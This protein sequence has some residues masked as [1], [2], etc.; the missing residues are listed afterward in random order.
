M[1]YVFV[2]LIAICSIPAMA[3]RPNTTKLTYRDAAGLVDSAGAIVLSTGANTFDRYVAN[4]GFCGND[5]VAVN[6]YAPT[7][8][9]DSCLIGLACVDK[10]DHVS[11]KIV[12]KPITCKEGK[13]GI[14]YESNGYNDNQI[15]VPVVCKAGKW[16]RQDGKKAAAPKKIVCKEGRVQYFLENNGINDN[17]VSVRYVCHSGKYV[18]D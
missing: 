4:Q 12:Q 9:K 15:A 11:S 18:R 3:A 13:T 2:M 8:D 5:E 14:S 16:V 6:A 1:K 17:S 10:E 7:L